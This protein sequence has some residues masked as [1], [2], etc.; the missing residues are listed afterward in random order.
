MG[1]FLYEVRRQKWWFVV[2]LVIGIFN[3]Y[4]ASRYDRINCGE[5]TVSILLAFYL[6]RILSRADEVELIKSS[7]TSVWRVFYTRLAVGYLYAFVVVM[8][9]NIIGTMQCGEGFYEFVIVEISYF[10]VSFA[11]V[12]FAVFARLLTRNT[13]A[14]HILVFAYNVMDMELHFMM[15]LKQISKDYMLFDKGITSYNFNRTLWGVNRGIFIAA[16]VVFLGFGILL[17]R[18]RFARKEHRYAD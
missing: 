2:L 6:G 9:F 15:L 7:A 1:Y 11:M 18:S 13:Y 4:G 17:F 16:G 14:S 12:A 3:M 10:A 5:D 8:V